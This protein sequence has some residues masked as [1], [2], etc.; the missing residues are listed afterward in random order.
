MSPIPSITGPEPRLNMQPKK[1]AE[2]SLCIRNIRMKTKDKSHGSEAPYNWNRK[3][4]G[5][6]QKCITGKQ[7]KVMKPNS[8]HGEDMGVDLITMLIRGCC[9]SK[10]EKPRGQGRPNSQAA[11]G[12]LIQRR[13]MQQSI[14][15]LKSQ[16][17]HHWEISWK[18][19]SYSRSQ[20]FIEQIS[21]FR[22]K[23]KL[24]QCVVKAYVSALAE[25][26]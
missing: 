20:K 21:N 25:A 7:L 14:S 3:P 18:E 24:N 1:P 15:S 4:N 11:V 22:G 9:T 8:L 10:P 2:T 16:K 6:Q 26:S 12:G 13:W 17:S 5:M 19:E 23:A